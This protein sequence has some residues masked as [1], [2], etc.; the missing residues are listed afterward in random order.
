MSL[1]L[2]H[3]ENFPNWAA[4][5]DHVV[6]DIRM[7][8]IEAELARLTE[9]DKKAREAV[10]QRQRQALA[11]QEASATPQSPASAPEVAKI[12]P[13]PCPICRDETE[14]P[15]DDFVT[16]PC[17]GAHQA[18]PE[19]FRDW[20]QSN[21]GGHDKCPMCRQ[22]LRHSCEHL[23]DPKLLVAGTIIRQ[24]TLE[25]PCVADCPGAEELYRRNLEV[26]QHSFRDALQRA[27]GLYHPQ[28]LNWDFQG[29]ADE[30][31]DALINNV[32]HRV[33]HF[34]DDMT[35]WQRENDEALSA[36][37]NHIE[38]ERQRIAATADRW[39]HQ[40]RHYEALFGQLHP[41][42]RE[43]AGNVV[44]AH[45]R[46]MLRLVE[47]TNEL[48]R[49]RKFLLESY[50][51]AGNRLFG[52]Y[53]NLG[54]LVR[55]L[56]RWTAIWDREIGRDQDGD[57]WRREIQRVGLLPESLKLWRE[58][59]GSEQ[60]KRL[61]RGGITS[62]E[63][64]RS[65]LLQ[66]QQQQQQQQASSPGQINHSWNGP[67]FGE[68]Q[69]GNANDE[70]AEDWSNAIYDAAEH[71]PAQANEDVVEEGV[72]RM[73]NN[74]QHQARPDHVPPPPQA[75]APGSVNPIRLAA[76]LTLIAGEALALMRQGGIPQ[77]PP[78]VPM[79]SN[80]QTLASSTSVQMW[81]VPSASQ[82]TGL[83]VNDTQEAGDEEGDWDDEE[84]TEVEVATPEHFQP[85][86]Q[87][88]LEPEWILEY[89]E[90]I[91]LEEERIERRRRGP[92]L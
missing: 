77:V 76:G 52:C 84:E 80:A 30:M 25:A 24:Q 40:A 3:P 66:Q 8:Q 86:L 83:V 14:Q 45:Q 17:K 54:I 9:E 85:Q 32:Y 2:F 64:A 27:E 20:I 91:R 82:E 19:C 23:M 44:D 21:N 61:S 35:R 65:L 26:F 53:M 47:R 50:R 46:D 75:A 33:N 22:S 29:I 34:G 10:A 92:R 38:R 6:E 36:R 4:Y 16:L 68:V 62:A 59:M 1:N 28:V 15:Q 90:Q 48:D 11:D 78:N 67:G 88:P 63:R 87:H 58:L 89:R 57:W 56:D 12:E 5:H 41:T 74:I 43:A 79:M 39:A 69:P 72:G 49:E 71:Q 7:S 13:E 60:A 18:H 31:L 70:P 55:R 73:D 37:I 81:S 42:L 51:L